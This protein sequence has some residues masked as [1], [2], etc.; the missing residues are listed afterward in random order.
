MINESVLKKEFKSQDVNRIRN[1]IKKDYGASTSILSGYSSKKEIR[2]EGDEW[3][4]DGRIWTVKNGIK[5][6][7]T[8]LDE[9]KKLVQ[10]P[11]TC[12][13]CS[14]PMNYWL[15]KKIYK[16]HGMC[17]NCMIDFEGELRRAGKYEEYHKAMTQS[18][19]RAFIED[20]ENWA[21]DLTKEQHDIVTEGGDLEE[22]TNGSN[23]QQ[24]LATRI[25]DFLKFA[26][27]SLN[28]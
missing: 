8:K 6:N 26:K 18:N 19:I 4:E 21:S 15:S 10:V 7:L 23:Q 22:W 28:R 2:R 1:I 5:Q 17:F 9:A 13:S 11:L 12:P 24:V 16:L 20:V 14:G 25:Q 3:E 27:D